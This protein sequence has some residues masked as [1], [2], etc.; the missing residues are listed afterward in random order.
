MPDSARARRSRLDPD[1]CVDADLADAAAWL[2]AGLIVAYPTDTFYGLAVDPMSPDAVRRLFSL[3][4]R[5]A[6]VALPLIAASIEQVTRTIGPLEGLS[7][8]L[9]RRFWPGPLSLILDAPD[10]IAVDVHGG[11]GTVA[12]RVPAHRIARALASAFGAPVTATSANRS[13]QPP[14][15]DADALVE[16]ASDDRVFVVDGGASPG[17]VPST[18]VDARSGVPQCIRAGAIAWDRVLPSR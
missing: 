14:A 4:G 13:G 10:A 8:D 18:I 1:R 15:A 6:R 9:A 16:I 3:K 17:G 5:D 7:A 2:R 11:A 12:V